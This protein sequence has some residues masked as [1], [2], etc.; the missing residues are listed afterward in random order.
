MSV[1][2]VGVLFALVVHEADIIRRNNKPDIVVLKTNLP[3]PNFPFSGTLSLSINVNRMSAERWL[4]E[5]IPQLTDI[6]LYD[7]SANKGIL[8]IKSKTSQQS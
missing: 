6:S 3:N 1:E 4:K 2:K 8:S 5:N 7:D